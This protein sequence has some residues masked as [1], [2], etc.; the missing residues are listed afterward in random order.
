MNKIPFPKVPQTLKIYKPIR[1]RTRFLFTGRCETQNFSIAL[2]SSQE[3]AMFI[4]FNLENTKLVS[5]KSFSSKTWSREVLAKNP[6]QQNDTFF[7]QIITTNDHFEV[8]SG[9]TFIFSLKYTVPLEK[10]TGIRLM[11]SMEM[12]EFEMEMTIE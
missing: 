8:F 10:I 2:I 7:I 9:G 11:E 4:E 5:A 12:Y 6:I 1:P 3:I